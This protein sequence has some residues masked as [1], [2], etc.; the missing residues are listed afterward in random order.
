MRLQKENKPLGELVRTS[1]GKFLEKQ[2]QLKKI[3]FT[4]NSGGGLL[5]D[6]YK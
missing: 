2:G 3:V 6:P 1:E 4:E 5:Q